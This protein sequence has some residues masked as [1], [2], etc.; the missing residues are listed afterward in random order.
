MPSA[1][2]AAASLSGGGALLR[3]C[4]LR[5][6]AAVSSLQVKKSLLL[7]VKLRGDGEDRWKGMEGVSEGGS[8][9]IPLS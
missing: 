7:R 8:I 9:N 4:C 3:Q 1:A 6:A 2:A 5:P